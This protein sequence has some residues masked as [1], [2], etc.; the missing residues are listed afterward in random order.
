M[1]VVKRKLWEKDWPYWVG[2]LALGIINVFYLFVAWKPLGI[3]TTMSV[4][5]AAF[6][7]A[8]GFSPAQWDY[9]KEIN[10]DS[11]FWR[12]TF[13]SPGT[14]LNIGIVAGALLGALV[15]WQFRIRAVKS[16]KYALAALGGG[17]L[18]GYG[19]R[20]APRC[21]IG[22]LLGDIPSLSLQGWVFALFVFIGAFIGAKIIVRIFVD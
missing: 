13:F 7:Q 21:N 2:G 8:L 17:F 1:V 11:S 6:W 4:W 19:A 9:F 10:F 18:M 14:W 3:T 5:G 20:L 12:Y 22:T 16:L 15:A